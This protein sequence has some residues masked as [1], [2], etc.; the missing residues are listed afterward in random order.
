MDIQ[1]ELVLP[2]INY[3]ATII[4]YTNLI[5]NILGILMNVKINTYGTSL[6]EKTYYI[7]NGNRLFGH[8]SAGIGVTEPQTR[9]VLHLCVILWGRLNPNLL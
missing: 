2:Q 9:S 3:V 4:D 7:Q 8:T 6:K 1:R 5:E